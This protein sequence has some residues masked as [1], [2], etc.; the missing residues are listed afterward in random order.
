MTKNQVIVP[1]SD[2]E[3][4]E[5]SVGHWLVTFEKYVLNALVGDIICNP[6]QSAAD[7]QNGRKAANSQW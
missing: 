1:L 5:N 2:Q 3:M 4:K 6:K 7:F